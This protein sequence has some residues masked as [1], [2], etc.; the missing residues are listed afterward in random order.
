MVFKIITT[1][2]FATVIKTYRNMYSCSDFERLFT[3]YKVGA[4]SLKRIHL[5]FLFGKQSTLQSLP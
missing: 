5:G 3:R 4:M 1:T 2:I